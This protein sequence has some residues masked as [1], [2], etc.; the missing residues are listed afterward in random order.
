MPAFAGIIFMRLR[1]LTRGLLFH[2][3]Q[4][5]LCPFYAPAFYRL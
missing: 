3:P 2:E 5:A 4:N 1:R